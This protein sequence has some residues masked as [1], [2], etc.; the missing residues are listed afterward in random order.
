MQS[1][2]RVSRRTT[3]VDRELRI[4]PGQAIAAKKRRSWQHT[5]HVDS[6]QQACRSV[7]AANAMDGIVGTT[8]TLIRAIA[9]TSHCGQ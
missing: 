2:W 4:A 1:G 6:A 8:G 5:I 9:G 3:S 7:Y